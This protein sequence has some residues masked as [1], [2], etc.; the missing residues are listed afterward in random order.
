[1]KACLL[2]LP[3]I[4]FLPFLCAD[5]NAVPPESVGLSVSGLKKISEQHAEEMR[6]LLDSIIAKAS[7]T[8]SED[9]LA[10]FQQAYLQ[11]VDTQRKT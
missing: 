7:E 11:Y 9:Q 1:M 8:L 2:F 5:V 10:L 4:I 6:M 3:I